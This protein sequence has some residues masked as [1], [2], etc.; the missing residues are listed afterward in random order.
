MT[1]PFLDCCQSWIFLHSQK[2]MPRTVSFRVLGT[3]QFRQWENFGNTLKKLPWDAQRK[4]GIVG[5][6]TNREAAAC[7]HVKADTFSQPNYG[8]VFMCKTLHNMKHTLNSRDNYDP[9]SRGD[10]RRP[11]Q[12]VWEAMKSL[13]EY[14]RRSSV[15][16]VD[17]SHEVVKINWNAAIDK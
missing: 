11:S 9:W 8:S 7:S 13:N 2:H 17:H 14:N 12:V 4:P 5:R 1:E 16:E 6:R 15:K 3:F 10:F